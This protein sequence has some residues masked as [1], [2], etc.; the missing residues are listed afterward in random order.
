MPHIEDEVQK[1]HVNYYY[2][3]AKICSQQVVT[4]WA[5]LVKADY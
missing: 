1:V 4:F 2:F 5:Q 3:I